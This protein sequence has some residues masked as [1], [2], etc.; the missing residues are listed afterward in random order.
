MGAEP[1][2][3]P[4]WDLVSFGCGPGLLEVVRQECWVYA[5]GQ[6]QVKQFTGSLGTSWWQGRGLIY[7]RT[8]LRVASSL[9]NPWSPQAGDAGWRPKGGRGSKKIAFPDTLGNRPHTGSLSKGGLPTFRPSQL[10]AWTKTQSPLHLCAIKLPFGHD[11]IT[12]DPGVFSRKGCT[13]KAAIVNDKLSST[14]VKVV[15]PD[16]NQ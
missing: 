10:Q 13:L 1:G 16:F 6:K 14:L 12:F 15:R 7:P 5:G 2:R 9:V 3:N 8:L 11:K 4:V